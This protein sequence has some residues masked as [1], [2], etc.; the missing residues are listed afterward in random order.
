MR[1][2]EKETMV[3]VGSGSTTIQIHCNKTSWV[4][5]CAYL[6]CE[7]LKHSP[8]FIQITSFTCFHIQKTENCINYL[9]GLEHNYAVVI[10]EAIL[11]TLNHMGQCVHDTVAKGGGA[12]HKTF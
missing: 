3:N 1:I 7:F 5:H 12:C 2:V 8:L 10:C 6:H 9:S 4:L 11:Q